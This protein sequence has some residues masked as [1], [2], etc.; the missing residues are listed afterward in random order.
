MKK[1]L[2]IVQV[3]HKTAVESL[4]K[5]LTVDGIDL[6][7]VGPMDLSGSMGVLGDP[8]HPEVMTAIDEVAEAG[9]VEQRSAVV[10]A[11]IAV[12]ATQP[13]GQERRAVRWNGE[14][15]IAPVQTH[16]PLARGRRVVAPRRVAGH[17]AHLLAAS[18]TTAPTR[19]TTQVVQS[20]IANIRGSSSTSPRWASSQTRL[21]QYNSRGQTSQSSAGRE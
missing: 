18:T 8:A 3:E 1:I 5:I 13:A 6:A 10:Q 19:T 15:V 20:L 4:D 11:A 16:D 7:M 9:R 17:Q 2:V 21:T 14:V 12:A